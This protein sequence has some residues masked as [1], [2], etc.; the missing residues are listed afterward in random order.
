MKGIIR[1]GG[2]LYIK[3]AGIMKLQMCPSTRTSMYCGDWCPQFSE[4][5]IIEDERK[6]GLK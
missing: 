3:R 1:E 5:G 2:A 6:C 4:I